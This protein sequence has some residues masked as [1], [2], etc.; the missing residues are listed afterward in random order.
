VHASFARAWVTSRNRSG[1]VQADALTLGVTGLRTEQ[2]KTEP[3][4]D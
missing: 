2:S 4:A 3:Q 1:Y